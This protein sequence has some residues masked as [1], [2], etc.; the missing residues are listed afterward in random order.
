VPPFFDG[1]MFCWGWLLMLQRRLDIQS[2]SKEFMVDVGFLPGGW[3]LLDVSS[4][5]ES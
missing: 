2:F 4:I 1:P 5:L 3:M